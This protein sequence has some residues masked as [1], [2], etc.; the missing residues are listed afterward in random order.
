MDATKPLMDA[1]G[2]WIERFDAWQQDLE[3]RLQAAE[4]SAVARRKR[5]LELVAAID[6]RRQRATA[7]AERAERAKASDLLAEVR[8][9]I[10]ELA[11][12]RAA[13]VAALGWDPAQASE[14]AAVAEAL[15]PVAEPGH[16]ELSTQ[17]T[18]APEPAAA[19]APAAAQALAAT[20]AIPPAASTTCVAAPIDA[21]TKESADRLGKFVGQLRGCRRESTLL[22]IWRELE[23]GLHKLTLEHA[24]N[25]L[26]ELAHAAERSFAAVPEA[27][28]RL[29]DELS[30]V[31][32]LPEAEAAYVAIRKRLHDRRVRVAHVHGTVAKLHQEAITLETDARKQSQ[33]LTWH[34]IQEICCRAKLLQRD[35]QDLITEKQQHT[36]HTEVFGRLGAVQKRCQL[37]YVPALKTDWCPDD[38][39][40]EIETS[41]TRREALH[42]KAAIPPAIAPLPAP[43]P[44]QAAQR[45][46]DD[47]VALADVYRSI[48]DFQRDPHADGAVDVLRAAVLAA[49]HKMGD[50]KERLPGLLLPYADHFATGG[51]FRWLRRRLAQLTDERDAVEGTV[52]DQPAVEPA[53]VEQ[54]AQCATE[55]AGVV[56]ADLDEELPVIIETVHGTELHPSVAFARSFTQ[57]NR[58]LLVGGVVDE[59][60]RVRLVEVLAAETVDWV[61]AERNGGMGDVHQAA[62]RLSSGKYDFVVYLLGFLSHKAT[63]ILDDAAKQGMIPIARVRR[64]FGVV[65]IAEAIGQIARRTAS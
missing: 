14:P 62:E 64:G 30:A 27:A 11:T 25:A 60:R 19:P 42:A 16:Q 7:L 26:R 40:A 8:A 6:V 43:T 59:V 58:I 44:E 5:Q 4:A 35:Y 52:C 12:E 57:G 23:E 29:R 46:Q 49:L 54:G 22:C 21:A 9:R 33:Q 36:L 56:H 65:G 17:P 18:A 2:S 10:D 51:D 13:L 61:T 1:E 41:R 63:G 48:N 37:A 53:D 20:I 15:G 39:I 24:T 47:A 55:P 3:M 38:L 32:K 28:T 34:S 50:G 31:A 45:A